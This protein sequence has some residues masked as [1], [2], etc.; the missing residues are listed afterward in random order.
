MPLADHGVAL[1]LSIIFV[2]RGLSPTLFYFIPKAG[3]GGKTDQ[4]RKDEDEKEDGNS[5]G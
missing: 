4:D 5:I 1:P 3:K 2:G